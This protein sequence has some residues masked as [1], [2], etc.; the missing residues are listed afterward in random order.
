MRIGKLATPFA[1]P[2]S[3][4]THRVAS[5]GEP[6][7]TEEVLFQSPPAGAVELFKVQLPPGS[8]AA[9]AVAADGRIAVVHQDGVTVLGRGGSREFQ[10][11]S[12]RPEVQAQPAFGADGT[13][14]VCNDSRPGLQ[15]YDRTGQLKWETDQSYIYTSDIGPQLDGDQVFFGEGTGQ[16]WNFD[17][18]GKR[19]WSFDTR[20]ERLLGDIH[21]LSVAGGTAYV[22]AD[23]SRLF[24]VKDGQELWSTPLGDHHSGVRLGSQVTVKDGSLYYCDWSGNLRK[25]N[26]AGEQDW[27]F[28]FRFMRR[29]EEIPTDELIPPQEPDGLWERL[30]V[31]I[32]GQEEP[33]REEA[34]ARINTNDPTTGFSTTPA[35][36]PDGKTIYVADRCRPMEG[37]PQLTAIDAESAKHLWST[38]LSIASNASDV[39]VDDSGNIYVGSKYGNRV[40]CFSPDGRRQWTFQSPGE[41]GHVGVNLDGDRLILSTESGWMHVLSS[42][43]LV[44]RS[45]DPGGE[46]EIIHLE[47]GDLQIGD[48]ELDYKD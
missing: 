28:A 5:A 22:V 14:Y 44:E 48:F 19:N 4:A 20:G 3:R 9:P 38:T 16:L 11:K 8:K 30:G 31:L 2:V 26:L 43:A 47:G 1:T 6:E 7:P 40:V 29:E 18:D 37:A 10:V 24:A 15:A 41:R 33:S 46:P 39:Q 45:A 27:R 12:A 35:F 42:Q 36:S 23:K 21:G 13:L 34:L 17:A 32:Q 25:Q